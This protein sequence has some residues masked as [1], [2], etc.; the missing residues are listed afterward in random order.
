MFAFDYISYLLGKIFILWG[1]GDQ[2]RIGQHEVVKER[3]KELIET[4]IPT[5]VGHNYGL[6]EILGKSNGPIGNSRNPNK[7]QL[8]NGGGDPTRV[9]VEEKDASCKNST[10]IEEVE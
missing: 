8:E 2:E 6:I 9:I 7:G 5:N 10:K 4:P 1:V 3:G